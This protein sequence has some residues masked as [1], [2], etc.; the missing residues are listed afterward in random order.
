MIGIGLLESY[1]CGLG[2]HWLTSCT[3]V[4]LALQER[5][6]TAAGVLF[7]KIV[8]GK[9]TACEQSYGGVAADTDCQLHQERAGPARNDGNSSRCA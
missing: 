5:I 8:T 4:V 3:R 7:A 1:D 9:T 2:S 6:G